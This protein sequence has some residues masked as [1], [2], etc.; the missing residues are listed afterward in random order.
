MGKNLTL[1]L[2]PDG[3]R[4]FSLLFQQGVIIKTQVGCSFREFLLRDLGLSYDFQEARIQTL[5]INGKAVDNP[6]KAIVRDGTTLALSGAMPGLVGATLR[7]G[8]SYASLRHTI[9]LSEEEDN[10]TKKEGQVVLKLFNLLVSEIGPIL[11]AKGFWIKGEDLEK[12]ARNVQGDF[13]S[14]WSPVLLNGQKMNNQ[15]LEQMVWAPKTEDPIL[16]K[17]TFSPDPSSL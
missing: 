12:F 14:H 8:G 10:V 7:R 3:L 16:I 9:T 5:F 11:L 15:V 2:K 13:W 4:T 6:E 1:T 17:I